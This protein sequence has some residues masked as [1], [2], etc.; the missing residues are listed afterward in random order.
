[1]NCDELRDDYGLYAL[2]IADDPE[3]SEIRA[4]LQRACPA[5][6][7]GVRS[8]RELIALMGAAAPAVEPPA[9]LRKR[10]LA[11][12]GGRTASRWNW[13]PVWAAVAAGALIAAVVFNIRAQRASTELARTGAVLRQLEVDSVS[14]VRELARL[15]EAFAILNQPNV[16]QVVF[17]G[18]A[19]QPPRGRVFLDPQRGVLLVASNLPPA[20]SGKIYEM[21]VIPKGGK[22]VPAGL[23]QSAADGTAVH[24]VPGPVDVAGTAAVAVTV[25]VVA[26]AQVPNLPPVFAAAL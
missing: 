2:G 6:V 12:V 11:S 26:G 9:R 24:V 4:H 23:F 17:G 14:Q 15:N 20:P 13:S 8:A 5:C 25:E 3:L 16:K 1:M 19:P 22:P 7:P 10:V 18:G 21:W